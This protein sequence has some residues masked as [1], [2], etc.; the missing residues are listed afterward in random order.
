MYIIG[1]IGVNTRDKKILYGMIDSG[2]NVIRLNSSHGSR[3]E[4]NKVILDIRGYKKSV[5]I[6]QDLTGSKIR[7]SK[8]IKDVIRVVDKEEIIFCGEDIYNNFISSKKV[9]PV[10]IPNKVLL[11]NSIEKISM[12]DNTMRF[13]IKGKNKNGIIV[14]VIRGGIVRGDKGCNLKGFIRKSI[15]S[16]KDKKDLDWA[17]NNSIDIVCQSFVECKEDIYNVIGYIEKRSYKFKPKIWAKI[18]SSNG[19]KNILE[20]I[21]I[22]DGIIIGRG[23]LVPETSLILTP[24]LQDKVIN[25][26]IEN[27][28]DIVLGTHIFDS[29]K[30]GREPDLAEVESI[31][32]NIKKGVNG[33]LLAGETSVG[34]KPLETVKFLNT[35]IRRYI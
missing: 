33:F 2:L 15:L 7:V 22:V 29:M 10:N 17:I 35:L 18:E 31:Y 19:V 9:V 16:N 25:I 21:K 1:T 8:K 13:K 6:L 28:K 5:H 26:A 32:N 23:D 24:I 3:E 4:F 11:N 14:E 12:K 20:I 34:K 27:N 30:N